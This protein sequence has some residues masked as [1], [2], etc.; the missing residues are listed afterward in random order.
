MERSHCNPFDINS[1]APSRKEESNAAVCLVLY[2]NKGV[3]RGNHFDMQLELR[4]VWTSGTD[5]YIFF[6]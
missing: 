6:K 5:S 2:V 3:G 1:R 4:W